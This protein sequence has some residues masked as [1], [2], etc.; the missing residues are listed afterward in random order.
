MKI[1]IPSIEEM[2]EINKALGGGVIN[3]GSLEFLISKIESKSEDKDHKKQIAKISAILWMEIIQRHPFLDGNKR[4]ATETVRLLVMK[5]KF[6]LDMPISGKVYISLKLAN[7][8]MSYDE[9]VK[10]IYERLKEAKL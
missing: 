6:V 3:R 5:N 7:N 8:E 2:V 1:T 4:T 9:L 10:T